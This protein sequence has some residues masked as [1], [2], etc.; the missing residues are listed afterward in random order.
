MANEHPWATT[1]ASDC[2]RRPRI[3]AANGRLF[4]PAAATS[5]WLKA[6]LGWAGA[7]PLPDT[8]S[9][10]GDIAAEFL[11]EVVMWWLVV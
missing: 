7:A 10:D 2:S 9:S 6:S 3:A 1:E 4:L 5:K 11:S 8:R